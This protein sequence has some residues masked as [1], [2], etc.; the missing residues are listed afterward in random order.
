[1]N[2]EKNAI[3]VPKNRTIFI[4][5]IQWCFD[6]F[7]LLIEKLKL[8]KND[9]VYLTWDI[10][11]KWPKSFETLDFIYNNRD[12]FITVTWNHELNFLKFLDWKSYWKDDKNFKILEKQISKR[13][14]LLKYLKNLPLYIKNEDFILVHWGKVPWKKFKD[15]SSNEITRIR[16]FNWQPWYELYS[17]KKKI[18]YWHWA[19][20][21]LRIT[22]NTIWIDTWCVYWK[23]LTA[24]ILETWEIIQQQALNLYINVF[25]NENK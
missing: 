17:K 22:K 3:E 14:E 25:K 13:P 18:I 15:H 16:D 12:K 19:L 5:D 6:E 4:W 1:M 7:M 20:D 21:W 9:I 10:I 8:L 23:M 2:T 24:Y 11:N